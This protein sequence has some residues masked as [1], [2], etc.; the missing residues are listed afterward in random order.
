L[1]LRGL[2]ALARNQRSPAI[3]DRLQHLTEK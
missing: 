2:T 1:L 3:G